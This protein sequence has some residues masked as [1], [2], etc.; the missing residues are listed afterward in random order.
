MK[1]KKDT[2]KVIK[3]LW[4]TPR[5]HA[6]I[7]LGFYFL[8]FVFVYFF[9]HQ[10]DVNTPIEKEKDSLTKYTEMDSYNYTYTITL[11]QKKEEVYHI[12]GTRLKE[13][14]NFTVLETNKSYQKDTVG[15]SLNLLFPISISELQPSKIGPLI[16]NIDPFSTT[17]YQDGTTKKEY[18][19]NASN[20]QELD[21]SSEIVTIIIKE[22]DNTISSVELNFNTI[23][24]NYQ[25]YYIVID[26]EGV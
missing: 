22:K 17:T 21:N 26:Y 15:D 14:D 13:N 11:N 18:Q 4:K 10:Y 2:F 6:L 7:L 8:F 24:T 3:E 25:E 1:K 16:K 23:I 9:I 20:F 19:I 12:K 5:Y